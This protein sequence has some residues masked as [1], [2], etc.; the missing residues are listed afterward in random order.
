M[1]RSKRSHAVGVPLQG[2]KLRVACRRQA[3]RREGFTAAL[4]AKASPLLPKGEANA[5]PSERY[6]NAE[7][8]V[9][10]GEDRAGSLMT[11]D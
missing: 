6:T 8:L 2:S 11:N 4:C 1:T 10:K 7:R 9:E 3:S 5:F